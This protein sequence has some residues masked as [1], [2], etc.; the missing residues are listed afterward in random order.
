MLQVR[1]HYPRPDPLALLNHTTARRRAHHHSRAHS[2]PPDRSTLRVV[3]YHNIYLQNTSKRAA[4]AP[5]N[6]WL[7]L[8]IKLHNAH[9]RSGQTTHR[10]R[11]LLTTSTERAT[12][13]RH[14][15]EPLKNTFSRKAP[16][17]RKPPRIAPIGR[18]LAPHSLG[19]MG[20][21]VFKAPGKI[22]P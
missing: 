6:A 17:K 13:G 19:F 21:G 2:I 11:E 16:P 9:H 4:H 15:A 8:T 20:G 14:E 3:N 12:H 7:S 18:P 10:H 22:R 1:A 5:Y